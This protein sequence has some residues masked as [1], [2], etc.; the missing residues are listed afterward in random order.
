MSIS[1]VQSTLGRIPDGTIHEILQYLDP[2]SLVELCQ[3]YPSLT[4]YAEDA[5][6]R[7]MEEENLPGSWD[8]ATLT[9][10]HIKMKRYR[11][12]LRDLL[13]PLV[14]TTG[15]NTPSNFLLRS[16][17]NFTDRVAGAHSWYK[18]LSIAEDRSFVFS[19]DLTVNM[20]Y[21]QSSA[22]FYDK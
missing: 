10:H 13:L 18:H 12:C 9:R 14:H 7:A 20:H 17:R 4:A 5:V 8:I 15:S 1:H 3:A 19:L 2:I 16:I 11:A 6:K 21:D 22:K